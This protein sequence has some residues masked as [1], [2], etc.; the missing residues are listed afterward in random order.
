MQTEK[1]LPQGS[2]KIEAGLHRRLKVLA[3]TCGQGITDLAEAFLEAGL[4]GSVQAPENKP[5]ALSPDRDTFNALPKQERECV[6]RLVRILESGHVVAIRA[7]KENLVAFEL[8]AVP[9][10]FDAESSGGST[11]GAIVGAK[12]ASSRIRETSGRD[13]PGNDGAGRSTSA[14]NRG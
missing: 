9:S 3:A 10:A 14:R 7:I 6:N 12:A 5:A 2:I 13:Q 4:S 8:L 11:A 1:T